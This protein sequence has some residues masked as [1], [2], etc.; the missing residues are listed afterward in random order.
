MQISLYEGPR[1]LNYADYIIITSG[2]IE[3]FSKPT[4]VLTGSARE[5]L[6][7][8]I[9]MHA[10]CARR[11]RAPTGSRAA[12]QEAGLLRAPRPARFAGARRRPSP[13]SHEVLGCIGR[14]HLEQIFRG[15][16]ALLRGSARSQ[17]LLPASTAQMEDDTE[18]GDV[19]PHRSCYQKPC[20][21]PTAQGSGPFSS[22]PG[23]PGWGAQGHKAAS[24]APAQLQ[25]L[26]AAS[27][28]SHWLLGH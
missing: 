11:V 19:K 24:A 13:P 5:R 21:M 14:A 27:R 15:S 3:G 20:A 25:P 4:S 16:T 26:H 23:S 9:S 6:A 18:Q 8:R 22:D 1:A 2:A 28:A 12:W 10:P 17:E 7:G